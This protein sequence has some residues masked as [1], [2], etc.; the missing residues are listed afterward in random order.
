M[1]VHKQHTT[2]TITNTNTFLHNILSCCTYTLAYSVMFFFL[3]GFVLCK[4]K[5]ESWSNKLKCCGISVKS[6]Q[7]YMSGLFGNFISCI[8]NFFFIPQQ[9]LYAYF[10][11]KYISSLFC[12]LLFLVILHISCSVSTLLDHLNET[13]ECISNNSWN[14]DSKIITLCMLMYLVGLGVLWRIKHNNKLVFLLNM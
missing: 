8:L 2:I 3:I 14:S 7:Y 13:S 11:E 10:L 4:V 5:M 6:T 9:N 12:S 1:Y